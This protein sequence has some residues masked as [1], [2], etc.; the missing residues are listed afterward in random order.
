MIFVTV[1]THEQQFNR[2]I[3]AID[4]YALK[5]NLSKEEVIVQGGYSTYKPKFCTLKSM[6]SVNEMNFYF[7]NADVIITHGGPGS[8]FIPWR[9]KK[10]IIAVPRQKKFGEHVDDHQVIFCNL[11]K[12]QNKVECILDI[13]LLEETINQFSLANKCGNEY[14]PNTKVFIE[15]FSREV[16]KLMI[17]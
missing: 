16:N 4:D 8:M 3:K 7:K 14:I 2:L 9:F 10:K 11:M 1:G 17:K 6:L 13:E 5:Y 15:K 12:E